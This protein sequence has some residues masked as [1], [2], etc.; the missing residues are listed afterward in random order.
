[1]SDFGADANPDKDRIRQVA[2]GYGFAPQENL[3]ID[4]FST[5]TSN[6]VYTLVV[7]IGSTRLKFLV[8]PSLIPHN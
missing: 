8:D 5:L 3:K 6:K 4:Q 2:F 1:M 7:K